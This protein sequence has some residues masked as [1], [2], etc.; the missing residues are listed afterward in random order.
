MYHQNTLFFEGEKVAYEILLS[1]LQRATS[2]KDFVK[3]AIELSK[4]S[5]NLLICRGIAESSDF[6]IQWL[7]YKIPEERYHEFGLN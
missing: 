1:K 7:K 2:L 3:F 6:V 5:S 4:I